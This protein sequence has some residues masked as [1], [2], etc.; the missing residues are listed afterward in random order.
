MKH[1]N[2]DHMLVV[3]I[4]KDVKKKKIYFQC[5]KFEKNISLNLLVFITYVSDHTICY[6]YN[7]FLIYDDSVLQHYLVSSK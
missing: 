3:F 7:L 1:S 2:I 6:T 4:S 5:K